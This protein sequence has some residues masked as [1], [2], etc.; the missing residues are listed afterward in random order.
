MRIS[1][2]VFTESVTI[3]PLFFYFYILVFSLQGMWDLSLLTRD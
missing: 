1:F 2:K 3:V